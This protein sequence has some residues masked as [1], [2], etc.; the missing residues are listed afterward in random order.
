MMIFFMILSMLGASFVNNP[1]DLTQED[2]DK[3]ASAKVR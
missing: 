2:F 1:K 3:A